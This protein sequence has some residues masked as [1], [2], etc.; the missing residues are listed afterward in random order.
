[1]A[2]CTN[3][4]QQ[5]DDAARAYTNCGA[6]LNAQGGPSGAYAPPSA[7]PQSQPGGGYAPPSYGNQPYGNQPYDN[8]PYDNQ[9]YGNQPYGGQPY[10]DQPYGMQPAG[11]GGSYA[12]GGGLFTIGEKRE[13]VTI[14]L[15]TI[16]TCGIYGIWWYYTYASEVK[17]ALGR[18]D[19]NPGMDL[20]LT[21]V[22]CGIYGI[23]AFFYKYPKLIMEM[24]QRAGLPPNDFSTLVLVLG[25]VFAPAA[26]FII[27]SEL[28]KTWDAMGGVR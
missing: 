28:N 25:L 4:G 13:P 23:Y 9:Q 12:G 7:P 2:F 26:I 5:N 8:Q 19:I 21:F 24:Q 3:C 10:G 18:Q 15:L 16:V 20:V 17:N 27:Q 22:T 11:Y 1:M 14:I 6:A